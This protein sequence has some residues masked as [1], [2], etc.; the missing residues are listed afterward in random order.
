[1]TSAVPTIQFTQTGIVVPTEAEVLAGVQVDINAAFGGGLNPALETPQGQLASSLAAIISD[2]NAQ[3]AEV[4]NQ[5]NPDYADG[6]WQD[7][8]G[9]IYF[10]SRISSAGTVVS[11]TVVGRNGTV[12]PVGAQAQN[13]STGDIYLCTSGVTI[14]I[15]GT[16]TAQFTSITPGPVACAAGA[17]DRIYQLIPGW[18]TITNASAGII[19]RNTETRQEFETQRKVSVALNANGSVQSVYANVLAVN[20]VLSAYAIDNPTGSPVTIGG[21]SLLANSIYVAAVGGLDAD[22]ANAIWT[23]K[24]GGCSYNGTTSVVVYDTNNYQAPYPQYTILFTR[25][26]S[27]PIFFDIQLRANTRLPTNINTL[28]QN[29]IVGAFSGADGG[30]AVSI[31]ADLFASRYYYPIALT[32]PNVEILSVKVGITTPGA[33]DYLTMNIDQYPTIDPLNITITQV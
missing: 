14:G 32:D 30:S 26:T 12:I 6:R 8:L 33:V 16:A 1:M 31:G 21:V 11:A 18:D 3:I 23:K 13:S 5:A 27:I 19:G 17:L 24:S 10:M 20:G 22:I 7:A 15:S 28:I 25:P 2:K 9:K 4:T 29:A